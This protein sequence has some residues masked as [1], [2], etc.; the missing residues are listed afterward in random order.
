MKNKPLLGIVGGAVPIAVTAVAAAW[1]HH[2]PTQYAIT[3][4]VGTFGVVVGWL[5]GFLASPYSELEEKRF[6]KYAATISAFLSGYALSKLEPTL[7]FIIANGNLV[8]KPLYGIRVL[9][10]F[11]CAIAAAITMYVFRL[12]T[13][14]GEPARH[15]Q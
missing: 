3:V 12:Y 1:V 14:V 8:T 2:T 9:A 11:I 5:I 6:S 7:N 13:H 15:R 10:F 4:I